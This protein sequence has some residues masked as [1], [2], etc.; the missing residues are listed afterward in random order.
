[1][2]LRLRVTNHIILGCLLIDFQTSCAGIKLR[3]RHIHVG[4]N[5]KEA[6]TRQVYGKQPGYLLFRRILETHDNIVL[7]AVFT[8]LLMP[9]K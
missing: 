8:A 9:V 4:I 2:L 1:M 5:H 6:A 7:G 3:H